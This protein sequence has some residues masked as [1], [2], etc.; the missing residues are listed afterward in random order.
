MDN[1]LER[2]DWD[3]IVVGAGVLGSFHAY[4]AARRG[5]RTLLLERGDWPGEA[6]VRNSRITYRTVGR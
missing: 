2:V 4:F 1:S 5:W 6:S 3:L